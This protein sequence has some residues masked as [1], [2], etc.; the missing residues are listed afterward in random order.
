MQNIG[1][2]TH[3][4]HERRRSCDAPYCVCGNGDIRRDFRQSI[5]PVNSGTS[6]ATQ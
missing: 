4:R 3:E 2:D 1:H 5:L 6:L